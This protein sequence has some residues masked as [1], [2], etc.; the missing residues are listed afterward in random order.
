MKLIPLCYLLH[1]VFSVSGYSTITVAHLEIT[2]TFESSQSP[3][4]KL[5]LLLS[6]LRRGGGTTWYRR[7]VVK[8]ISSVGRQRR[9]P[10][11]RGAEPDRG[12]WGCGPGASNCRRR[13]TLPPEAEA[14]V[15]S[16]AGGVFCNQFGSLEGHQCKIPRCCWTPK[17]RLVFNDTSPP[18]INYCLQGVQS[19]LLMK[20]W[21]RQSVLKSL[22]GREQMGPIQEPISK[23]LSKKSEHQVIRAWFAVNWW[24]NRTLGHGWMEL[25]L[26]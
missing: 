2:I 6:V 17:E 26:W 7:H 25:G 5:L 16:M 21:L 4:M 11:G 22:D 9:G 8:G 24:S 19:S 18:S 3:G 14:H 23:T 12:G 13:R 15:D 20:L 1:K 10:G